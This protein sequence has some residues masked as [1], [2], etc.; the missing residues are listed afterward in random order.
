MLVPSLFLSLLLFTLLLLFFS[1]SFFLQH[2][3]FDYITLFFFLSLSFVLEQAMLCARFPLPLISSFF[4]LVL[5]PRVPQGPF[6][7]HPWIIRT[8]Q[9]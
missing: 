2:T 5:K 8:S 3:P 4:L 1:R 6:P 9:I 7:F